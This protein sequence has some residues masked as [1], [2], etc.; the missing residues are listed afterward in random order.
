M[1]SNKQTVVSIAGVGAA[2]AL[3]TVSIALHRAYDANDS[4]LRSVERIEAR[5]DELSQR[6]D[7]LLRAST[8]SQSTEPEGA[9]ESRLRLI[10]AQLGSLLDLAAE[11]QRFFTSGVANDRD[12]GDSSAAAEESTQVQALSDVYEQD[13]GKSAWGTDSE[14][15]LQ[16][17]FST[18]PFFVKHGGD[19]ETDCRQKTCRAQ[20]F[21][22][23]LDSLPTQERQ[24][25][26]MM[27]KYE[28][29]AL[30]AG[31]SPEVGRL[32]VEWDLDSARPS[33]AVVYLRSETDA[34]GSL[35]E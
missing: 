15:L 27:S 28:L 34:R 11:E 20:W 9:L 30:A 5:N 16:Q 22:P 23:E 17:G 32:E 8:K 26:I 25:M 7:E 21:V 10:E 24:D 1:G 4:L 18:E 19:L 31:T 13:M 33:I 14:A 6:I 3:A 2:V 12:A 29:L 35:G